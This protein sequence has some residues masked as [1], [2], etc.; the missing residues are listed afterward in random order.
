MNKE[1]FDI[2]LFVSVIAGVATFWFLNNPTLPASTISF[3]QTPEAGEMIVVSF[4]SSISKNN[5]LKSFSISPAIEGELQWFDEYN[6]LRFL[7]LKGFDSNKSYTV[8]IDRSNPL[9]AQLASNVTKKTFQQKGLPTKF[10]ARI[11]GDSTIY[12]ITESGLKRPT[13][14]EVFKSYPDNKAED[15]RVIDKWTLELYPNNVLVR[16]DQDSSVYKLEGGIKKHIQNIETFNAMGLDWDS[17][18]PINQ[19]E[20]DSYLNGEPIS[21][22]V[23]P[24]EQK[25]TGKFIDVNLETM[26]ATM[27]QDGKI[28]DE[29][30]VA[31]TGNPITSPT[32]RGFFSVIS[33]ESNHFSS[34]SRVWMP[35][36][37]RYSGDYYL[38]GWPYWPNGTRLTSLYSSG[39][40]RLKDDDAK[41]IF[42]FS[43]VGTLV[44]IR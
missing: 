44:N 10:N 18:T 25:P 39:C 31:G 22:G 34:L 35:W 3:E 27:W 14:L 41:K 33:K 26:K 11:P 40:V 19:F 24:N 42:D 17:I 37:V 15:I 16:L 5:A 8:S 9:F 1:F 12:Y 23:L 21:I 28:I 20:F 29:V 4:S 13:T 2:K 36:S 30:P 38:H 43:E 32:R 6:E 7:P